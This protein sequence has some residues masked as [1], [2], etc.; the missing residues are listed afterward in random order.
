M[1][2]TENFC[3]KKES[4]IVLK[5]YQIEPLENLRNNQDKRG[6]LIYHEIGSGK[7]ITAINIA[8][9]LS[10]GSIYIITAAALIKNF[11]N[12]TKK[13]LNKTRAKNFLGRLKAIDI[14]DEKEKLPKSFEKNSFLI[15]DECQLFSE[16]L[17]NGSKLCKQIYSLAKEEIGRIL[18]LSATP[19]GESPFDLAPIFNMLHGRDVLPRS[20]KN[21]RE[22]FYD[23]LSGGVYRKSKF[24]KV[25]KGYVSYFKGLKYDRNVIAEKKR[26]V[27]LYTNFSPSHWKS[28][29]SIKISANKYEPDKM[30]KKQELGIVNYMKINGKTSYVLPEF[31]EHSSKFV[32]VYEKIEELLPEIG[33]IFVYSQ[34]PKAIEHFKKFLEANGWSNYE[35]K[36]KGAKVFLHGSSKTIDSINKVFNSKDNMDGSKIRLIIGSKDISHGISL[37]N[38]RNSFILE[39]E[40]SYANLLQ[41]IGRIR[42]LCSHYHFEKKYRNTRQY[43]LCNYVSIFTST[44]D[45]QFKYLAEMFYE[46]NVGFEKFLRNNKI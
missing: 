44:I 38:T 42:R 4:K 27:F 39:M 40:S 13:F 16:R 20:G 25:I 36:G 7:T 6:L 30:K 45:Y 5:D 18:F 17:Y 37:F 41:I 46:L 9:E 28:Y 15:F 31:S 43:L 3:E 1:T 11:K 32:K 21:F 24:K 19:I 33:N 23:E 22:E 29:D 14:Y 35:K 10:K 26:N 2:S 34:F 8:D 12:E